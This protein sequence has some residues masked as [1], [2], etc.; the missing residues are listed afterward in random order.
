MDPA[1]AIRTAIAASDYPALHTFFTSTHPTLNPGEQRSL[2]AHF[3]SHAVSSPTFF[4]S[5]FR[6]PLLAAVLDVALSNLPPV[7]EGGADNALRHKMFEFKVER[8][9]YA[10]A[11]RVLSGMKM[12]DNANSV[13]YAKPVDRCDVFVKV[14]ECY[15]EE[16]MTVEAEGAVGKAGGVIEAHGIG[17]P[18]EIA[19]GGGGASNVDGDDEPQRTITLLLR[20]K[21]T[22]ARILDSNRKFLQAAMKYYDLSTAYLH[23]DDIDEEELIIMLGKAV[24]CAILSPNSAQRQR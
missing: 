21:S 13:Y 22:Y 6:S 10:A 9:D 2:S 1:T 8:G 14:A 3:I 16:D 5:A 17:F 20:Y 23:T 12:D 7:V 19:E 15:L 11:A 4:P 18:R 24:T